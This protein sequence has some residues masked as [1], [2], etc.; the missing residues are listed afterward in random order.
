MTTLRHIHRYMNER[1]A[2]VLADGRIG[3]IARVDP[4]FPKNETV[5]TVWLKDTSDPAAL[6]SVG[7]VPSSMTSSAA[8]G[9]V[10][11]GLADVIGPA[12]RDSFRP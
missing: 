9:L 8:S 6:S 3:K 12:E 7:G 11:V 2:I 1:R 5:V 4:F 10:K